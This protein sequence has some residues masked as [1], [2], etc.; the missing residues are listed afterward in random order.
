MLAHLTT[1]QAEQDGFK[2]DLD[3]DWFVFSLHCAQTFKRLSEI[4]AKVSNTIIEGAQKSTKI[5][6]RIKAAVDVGKPRLEIE[7]T[8]FDSIWP[9]GSK[10]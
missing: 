2:V 5:M 9:G 4:H 6:D 1:N 8:D 3:V 7:I 10:L